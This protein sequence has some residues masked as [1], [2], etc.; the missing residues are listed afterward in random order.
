LIQDPSL[1][2]LVAYLARLVSEPV[3]YLGDSVI[4][5]VG[6]FCHLVEYLVDS[7]IGLLGGFCPLVEYLVD[8]VIGLVG[9]FCPLVEYLA[10][11]VIGLVKYLGDLVIS[12]VRCLCDLVKVSSF[13]FP[14]LLAA[15]LNSAF[16]RQFVVTLAVITAIGL[17]FVFAIFLDRDER[18]QTLRYLS[19]RMMGAGVG[20]EGL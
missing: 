18:R 5:L 19:V 9:G 11:S 4:G 17:A 2:W 13:S 10:D 7:V 15:P 20:G 1:R 3:K 14:S 16:I 8:S 6:G 12:L